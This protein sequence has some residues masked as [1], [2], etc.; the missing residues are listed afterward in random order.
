MWWPE[1]DVVASMLELV[2]Q[3]RKVFVR[4]VFY[5]YGVLFKTSSMTEVFNSLKSYIVKVNLISLNSLFGQLPIPSL[6]D[7]LKSLAM[8][9]SF[10]VNYKM[11]EFL[12]F[13]FTWCEI[14][15]SIIFHKTEWIRNRCDTQL[16][17]LTWKRYLVGMVIYRCSMMKIYVGSFPRFISF[18]W[19]MNLLTLKAEAK[20]HITFPCGSQISLLKKDRFN[21]EFMRCSP[22]HHFV[23][24]LWKQGNL[25][26]MTYLWLSCTLQLWQTF[27]LLVHQ[28][29]GFNQTHVAT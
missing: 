14:K 22:Y 25:Y 20:G 19:N 27:W 15:T 26:H 29:I 9:W 4:I 21:I 10:M 24:P 11:L 23:Q 17:S 16:C 1:I 6:E 18:A 5:C 28:S 8:A 13:L 2:S 3:W 7:S 12:T